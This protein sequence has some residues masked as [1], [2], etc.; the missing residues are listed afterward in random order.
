MKTKNIFAQKNTLLP[1][2]KG[3]IVRGLLF[4]ALFI[5]SACSTYNPT[6]TGDTTILIAPTNLTLR[7]V[8]GAVE[9]NWQFNTADSIKVKEYRVY[10]RSASEPAFKRIATVTAPARR[11]RDLTV[12]VG[13][14]YQY[15][16]AAANKSSVEGQP[17][18]AV[19]VTPAVF[20]V[21]ANTG[22]KFT[23]RRL[24]TLSFNASNNTAQM[25]I[26]NDA[27]FTGAI[28]E[29]F[30]NSKI[31]EL[32]AG[33]GLKTVFAKFRT[34]EQAE[35]DPVSVNITLDTIA[36]INAITHDGAG[37]TLRA[38]DVLHI[39]LEAGEA[40]GNAAVD[41][42]DN[43]S[44]SQENNLR[45]YDNGSNGDAA[46]NDGVYELDYRIRPDLEFVQAFAYGNFSD[47]AAN[48]ALQRV[49]PTSFSVQIPPK[50]VTLSKP[51]A[52]STALKLTW[53]AST[54]RDFANYRVFRSTTSPVDSTVAPLTIINDNGTTTFRDEG[55]AANTNYFYRVFVYDR[56]GLFAGSNEV[57][58]LLKK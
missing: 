49:S 26:A 47:A 55:V 19:T 15:Q 52:D 6:G 28:W 33:D 44:S 38:G 57:Q 50:P 10:R 9:A 2:L 12:T 51:V 18:D 54:E 13:V 31:W 32:A 35:S 29:A 5:L 11:Y 39:R 8:A 48:L 17:S 30:A 4:A 41:L 7:L 40:F 22:A 46:A 27:A 36:L 24:I 16:I 43:N 42:N 53:T 23:N 34:A 21:Q 14:P 1:P 58:G 45:L 20:G 56:S 37:R 25:M 3:G